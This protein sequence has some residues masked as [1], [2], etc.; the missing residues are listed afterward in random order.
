MGW[1]RIAGGLVDTET[2]GR[3]ASRRP[4]PSGRGLGEGETCPAANP[5]YAAIPHSRHP[6]SFPPSPV[7]PPSPRHSRA[8][9]NPPPGLS[10]RRYTAGVLD[11]VLNLSQDAGMTMRLPVIIWRWL[12]DSVSPSPQPSPAG[13]GLFGVRRRWAGVGGD[14]GG[15]KMRIIR[16]GVDSRFRGND[17][18]GQEW[19]WLTGMTVAGRE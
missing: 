10:L 17:G 14:A 18:A 12:N 13:R 16:L 19:R 15:W 8:S 4:S 7:T 5:G 3:G 1:R 11:S 6:P 9:G 2:A